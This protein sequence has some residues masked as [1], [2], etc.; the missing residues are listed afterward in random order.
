MGPVEVQPR[1]LDPDGRNWGKKW[2]EA[3]GPSHTPWKPDDSEKELAIIRRANTKL[4]AQLAA[5]QEQNKELAKKLNVASETVER[6]KEASVEEL[7]RI[8]AAYQQRLHVRRWQIE[9]VLS[10]GTTIE[11]LEAE[12]F[13]IEDPNQR[14]QYLVVART[15]NS[16]PTSVEAEW[17][18]DLKKMLSVRFGEDIV[19]C[20]IA[21]KDMTISVLEVIPG[22]DSDE[23]DDD[24]IQF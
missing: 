9:A 7:S 21:P 8:K 4:V 18:A 3:F 16:T 13:E 11:G 14:L 17:M 20:V 22:V 12:V 6:V 19:E 1:N 24:L 15:P 2:D 10:T 23:D 5:Q